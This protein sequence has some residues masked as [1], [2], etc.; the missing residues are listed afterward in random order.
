MITWG[1]RRKTLVMTDR[2]A[3]DDTMWR[4]V[5][6][7][8]DGGLTIQGHDLGRDVEAVFGCREYEFTR[9][10]S[11]RETAA[12]RRLLGVKRRGDLL[13]AVA[14]RFPA[15]A[16]LERFLQHHGIDGTFWSRTGG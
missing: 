5:S 2:V 13:G 4:A 3:E 6:V 7:E 9:R 16:D 12:L 8:T 1:R 14:E 11:R 10:L 15:T